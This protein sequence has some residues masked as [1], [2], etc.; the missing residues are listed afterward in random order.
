LEFVA[1]ELAVIKGQVEVVR[2]V[3]ATLDSA[4][5][6]SATREAR[7]IALREQLQRSEEE[8]SQRMSKVMASFQRGLFVG[9]DAPDLPQDNL[10]LERWFRNPKSHERRIHGHH[11]AGVRIVLEGPTLIHALDHHQ[12]HPEPLTAAELLPFRGATPPACQVS[13]LARRTLMRRA[14]S[15]KQRPA[16]LTELEARYKNST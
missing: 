14:R 6:D 7:F 1:D 11:H 10:D 3:S 5:G 8:I 15:T 9:G 13:A 16:L 4:H 12:R 2:A